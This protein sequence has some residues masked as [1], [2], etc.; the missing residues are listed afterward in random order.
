MTTRHQ[1][2]QVGERA[3][4]WE[5]SSPHGPV[6]GEVMAYFITEE[7]LVYYVL[8]LDRQHRG[9]LGDRPDVFVSALVVHEDNLVPERSMAGVM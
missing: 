9:Y 4:I 3:T 7:G 2:I 5:T 6:S 8:I 1:M